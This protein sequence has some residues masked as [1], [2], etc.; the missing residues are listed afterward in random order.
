MTVQTRRQ[1][2]IKTKRMRRA[3][4]GRQPP[5]GLEAP[6]RRGATDVVN[7]LAQA[8]PH[9]RLVSR[10]QRLTPDAERRWGSLTPAEMLCHLGDACDSVLGI[11]IPP[12]PPPS[13][14][15]KPV[16]KWL[17][18][19]SPM[20]W[21]KGAK[22]R[23]G[24]DPHRDG[25][26]PGEFERDRARVIDGLAALAAAPAEHLAAAHFMVGPMSRK[27]WHRWAYKHVDHHLRQFGL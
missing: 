23:P 7:S 18:L 15:A 16:L 24:V 3:I 12:G 6:S 25:T 21:P 1:A 26:R 5:T 9:A 10:L 11:R 19:Y 8:G 4:F 20:P 14:V 17:I 13:G 2:P 22:T 27:D